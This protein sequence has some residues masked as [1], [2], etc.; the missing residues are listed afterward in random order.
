MNSL[1]TPGASA[2]HDEQTGIVTITYRGDITRTEGA[3]VYGWLD[4][5]ISTIG[6]DAIYGE[7]FDFR[8][9]TEFM[10]DNLM[11]ARSKSRSLNLRVD[12]TRFPV[13]MIV[14]DF[15]QQE[16]LR[17]PMQNVPRNTRKRIVHSEAEA[18]NFFHEWHQHRDAS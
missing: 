7:I 14:K 3:A 16:I 2:S 12:T 6:V 10:S 1:S 18:L 5:L 8:Q 15:Y 11:E 9:V 4:E 17:G 13:A